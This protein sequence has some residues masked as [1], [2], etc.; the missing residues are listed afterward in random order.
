MVK[1]LDLANSEKQNENHRQPIPIVRWYRNKI[2][3]Q[4]KQDNHAK[5]EK[6]VKLKDNSED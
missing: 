5:N 2:L 4:I 3:K 6:L 1:F